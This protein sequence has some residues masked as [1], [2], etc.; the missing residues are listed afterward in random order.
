MSDNRYSVNYNQPLA[1]QHD[2]AYLQVLPSRK[3]PS[4]S[5]MPSPK[6]EHFNFWN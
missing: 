5:K 3:R 2:S 4:K 1:I 6:R